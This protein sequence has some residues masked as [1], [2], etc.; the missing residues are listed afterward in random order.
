[1]LAWIA[2]YDI[3][4][5]PWGAIQ[6]GYF[7]A[8]SETSPSSQ[9]G[10]PIAGA[11]TG[12]QN[13][14]SYLN[15]EEG[16]PCTTSPAADPVA[17]FAQA[18]LPFPT[19]YYII[20]WGGPMDASLSAQC[21]QPVFWVA[22]GGIYTPTAGDEFPL[23][24]DLPIPDD[25]LDGSVLVQNYYLGIITPG[26]GYTSMNGPLFALQQDLAGMTPATSNMNGFGPG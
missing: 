12:S 20:A 24:V 14:L 6:T 8:P 2:A 9:S 10:G 5:V 13:A 18:L 16:P 23:I 11:L 21:G 25:T 17:Y 1:M 4:K 26:V 3:N 15:N 7:L 22:K 19:S